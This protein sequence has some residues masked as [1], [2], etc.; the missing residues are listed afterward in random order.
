[1]HKRLKNANVEGLLTVGAALPEN[2]E[3]YHCKW[4]NVY[5]EFSQTQ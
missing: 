4:R 5:F 2:N 3:C 1:M